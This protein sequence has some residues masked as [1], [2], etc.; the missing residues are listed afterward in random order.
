VR[1]AVAHAALSA[2]FVGVCVAPARADS[3]AGPPRVS[4]MCDHVDGPGRVRCDVE[5]RVSPGDSITW[6]DVVILRTPPFAGALR[7]RVGPH[8]ATVREP[9]V[10][11]WALALV[12]R[13]RGTG[14]VDAKVRL[15][16]CQG[17]VCAPI[18]VAVVGHVV[19]G[20]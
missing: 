15:V 5:A 20:E 1:S 4:M 18:E 17:K 14:D 16:V 7:G 19:A 13:T 11:R 10:W 2:A 12:A 3:D 6:G 8:E 9:E